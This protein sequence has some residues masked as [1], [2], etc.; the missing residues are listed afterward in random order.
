LVQKAGDDQGYPRL[1]V[2]AMTAVAIRET[3]P[4]AEIESRRNPSIS[5]DDADD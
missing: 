3:S 4:L 1:E 2:G 5:D